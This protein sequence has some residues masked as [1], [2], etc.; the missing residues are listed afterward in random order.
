MLDKSSIFS[1]L[2]GIYSGVLRPKHSENIFERFARVSVCAPL[3]LYHV[4][5]SF[6]VA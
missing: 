4:S 5:Q 6:P 1:A 3:S 2:D